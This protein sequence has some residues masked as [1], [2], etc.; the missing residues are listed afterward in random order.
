[1]EELFSGQSYRVWAD[2]QND[3]PAVV[4]FDPW[5]NRQDPERPAFGL[6]YFSTNNINVVAVKSH[7]NH[8]YQHAEMDEVVDRIN[9]RLGSRQRV[10]YGSSMGGYG[11]LNFSERLSLDR[12][13]LFAP[14]FSA[15]IR[16][17]PWERRWQSEQD[18]LA[19]R[20]DAVA[21]I[22]PVGGYIF[23][24]PHNRND[25]RHADLIRQRH[26]LTPIKMPFSGHHALDWFS[27][28]RTISAL[29]RSLVFD[30]TREREAIRARRQ[31]RAKVATYWLNLS[32]HLWAKGRMGKAL[33]AARR[34]AA[35]EKGDMIFARHT[36]AMCLYATGETEAA[37]A[38]WQAALA[39]PEEANRQRWLLRQSIAD[40]GW[41]ELRSAFLEP[42]ASA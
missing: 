39:N 19:C 3:G 18:T 8:W 31:D 9:E 26:P 37:S 7:G 1:M 21:Q 4:C 29:I 30:G 20:Y 10:G 12:V 25:Q 33:Q 14:Q 6:R 17:V 11:A 23:F 24:D 32:A 2:L 13:L 38:I 15:D 36:Y 41:E 22:A 27:Q 40:H 34:G 42:A 16:T 35:C 5:Y 28:N